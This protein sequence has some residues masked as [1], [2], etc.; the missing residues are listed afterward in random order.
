MAI[1]YI[2]VYLIFYLI[3]YND[4]KNE[5]INWIDNN[6]KQFNEFFGDDELHKITKEKLADDEYNY[7][8]K[9]ILGVDLLP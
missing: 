1:V 4:I 5:I 2:D 6:R 3:H 7:I 9:R 8:K